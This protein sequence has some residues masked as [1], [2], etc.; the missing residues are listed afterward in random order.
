MNRKEFKMILDRLF[1]IKPN[2]FFIIVGASRCATFWIGKCLGEHPELYVHPNELMFFFHDKGRK[3]NYELEGI[4]RYYSIFKGSEKKCGE[5]SPG[6]LLD[7]LAAK[8]I[9][10]NFPNVKIIASLRNPVKRFHSEKVY[11]KNFQYLEFPKEKIIDGSLYYEKLLR[12]YR[13]F[14]KK[15]IKIVLVEDIKKDPVRFIQDIYKFLEVN[16]DFIPKNAFEKANQM[17]KP[18]YPFLEYYRQFA[19]NFAEKLKYSNLLFILNFFRNLGLSRLSW[20][21]WEKNRKEIKTPEMHIKEKEELLNIFLDD[22]NKTE[23]LIKKDLS[24]WKKI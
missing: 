2:I 11:F 9:K 12:Y 21:I 1:M 19:S 8:T 7:P 22:I 24:S 10:N 13:L 23:R 17:S 14:P 5:V 20:Y 3:S 4:D 18:R 15:N 16:P 6:Y